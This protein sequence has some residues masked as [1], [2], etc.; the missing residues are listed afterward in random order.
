[1]T[2]SIVALVTMYN[3][4]TVSD[5]TSSLV[6]YVSRVVARVDNLQDSSSCVRSSDRDS[7]QYYK[8]MRRPE[9]ERDPQIASNLKEAIYLKHSIVPNSPWR[10]V[11]KDG[12][13]DHI[14]AGQESP[15][16]TV[17]AMVTVVT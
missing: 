14:L 4:P 5:L 6:L 10:P 3:L 9:L 1:V 13:A 16:V 12:S 8:V 17:Q 7:I 11:N 15:D 2:R